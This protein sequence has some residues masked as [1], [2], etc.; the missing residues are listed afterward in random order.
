MEECKGI[1]FKYFNPLSEKNVGSVP[2]LH[3]V[4][5]FFKDFELLNLL[6]SRLWIRLNIFHEDKNAKTQNHLKAFIAR[7]TEVTIPG[8][9]VSGFFSKSCF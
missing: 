5:C 4:S 2:W 3:K 9:S 7:E 1:Y 6:K 8:T